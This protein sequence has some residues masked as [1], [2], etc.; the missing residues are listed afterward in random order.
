MFND[1]QEHPNPQNDYNEP[2][3]VVIQIWNA[4]NQEGIRLFFYNVIKIRGV[5]VHFKIFSWPSFSTTIVIVMRPNKL[6]GEHT[7]IIIKIYG[8][9]IVVLIL[10]SRVFRATNCRTLCY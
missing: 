4:L 5:L 7:N 2:A 3:G 6:N 8:K 1:L 10:L 9:V